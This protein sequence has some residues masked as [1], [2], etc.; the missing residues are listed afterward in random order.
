[1]IR[2]L[3]P[4]ASLHPRSVR[5]PVFLSGLSL[6]ALTQVSWAGILISVDNS[7]TP[8]EISTVSA[9]TWNFNWLGDD[10]YSFTEAQFSLKKDNGA[11][12]GV[13]FS[14]WLGSGGNLPGNLLVRQVDVA[15][16]NI[17]QSYGDLQTIAFTPTILTNGTYS[18]Q[19]TGNN[20][21][22]N[23]SFA[24]KT[25]AFTLS[26]A[27]TPLSASFFNTD[28]NTTGTSVAILT[29]PTPGDV[30]AVPEPSEFLLGGVPALLG[31]MA[32]LRRRR[33]RRDE[34]SAL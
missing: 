19:L 14:L 3:H 9:A 32:V 24:V 13:T 10:A 5:P 25:G 21:E 20:G 30:A 29:E 17:T 18:I 12:G 7:G 26:D 33:A 2:F 15:A 31:G 11:T 4:D 34:G 16:A 22:A 1:M 8:R 28:G 6:L 27:G 23:K